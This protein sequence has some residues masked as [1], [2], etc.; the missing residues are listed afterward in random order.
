MYATGAGE[1]MCLVVGR[2]AVFMKKQTI[3]VSAFLLVLIVLLVGCGRTSPTRFGADRLREKMEALG[4]S[5]IPLGLLVH[6]GEYGN[7]KTVEYM[8]RRALLRPA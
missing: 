1:C 2:K 5:D 7:D 8:C 6:T 3:T 4:S